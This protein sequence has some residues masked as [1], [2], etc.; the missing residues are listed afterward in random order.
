VTARGT[1]IVVKR[2]L[3]ID[4]SGDVGIEAWGTGLE[5]LYENATLGLFSLMAS[6]KV[7]R[8]VKRTLSVVSSSHEDLLVDWL[9]EVISTAAMR[10]EVYSSVDLK[11]KAPFQ[12]DGT[13]YGEPVDST[14]H[15]LRFE[16]KAATYHGLAFGRLNRGYHARVI[17]DL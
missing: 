9:S 17:F 8:D 13:I 3:E 4:H 1:R 14:R 7:E 16:V 2:F 6:G 12:L 10:G 5:E 15:E 11:F